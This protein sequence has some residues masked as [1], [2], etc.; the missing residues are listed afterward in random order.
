[1]SDY[2]LER[3]RSVRDVV[4]GILLVVAGPVILGHSVV[5]TVISVL[6]IGWVA[7]LSGVFALVGALFPT[8]KGGFWSTALGGGLLLVLG[9]VFLRN[10][11]DAAGRA[12][13]R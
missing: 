9:I 1:M 3:R 10:H 5:A 12:G 2:V 13:R 8:G 11:V 7:P 4:L 6:L